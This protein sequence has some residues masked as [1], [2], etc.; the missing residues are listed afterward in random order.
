MRSSTHRWGWASILAPLTA[1][2]GCAADLGDKLDADMD[3][4][5]DTSVY[6]E[7]QGDGTIMTRLDA[8]DYEVWVYF[9]LDTDQEVAADAA[10]DSVDWDLGVQRSNIQLNGGASGPGNTAVA[11]L[12]DADFDALIQA[13]DADY[14]TDQADANGD[15]KPEYAMTTGEGRWFDY[16]VATHVLTPKPMVYVIRTTEGSHY[17]LIIQGY[18]DDAGTAAVLSVR[19]GAMDAPAQVSPAARQ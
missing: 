14:V 2:W 15:G 5:M 11:F 10:G 4:G 19:W 18:Y 12:P 1:L 8:T 13:P 3:A 7:D 6:S 16:D 17:K 9:D